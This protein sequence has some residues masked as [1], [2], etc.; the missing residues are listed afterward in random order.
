M[1]THMMLRQRDSDD[2]RLLKARLDIESYPHRL[3][4]IHDVFHN[5]V[6][7][8]IYTASAKSNAAARDARYT[9]P[10]LGTS[11]TQRTTSEWS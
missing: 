3:R 6:A 4:R 1:S 9:I 10:L 8:C 5:C 7:N 11:A 2:Q